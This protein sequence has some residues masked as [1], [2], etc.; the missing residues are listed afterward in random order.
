MKPT[1][2]VRGDKYWGTRYWGPR[3]RGSRKLGI[4]TKDYEVKGK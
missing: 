4:V 1:H 2:Q 3:L